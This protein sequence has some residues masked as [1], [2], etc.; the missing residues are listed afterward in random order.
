MSGLRDLKISTRKTVP[1]ALLAVRFS[2]SGG[3][4]GQNV[5]KTSTKV[6]LRLDLDAAAEVLG[7]SAVDRIRERLATRL[8]GDGCLQVVSSEHRERS[9]NLEAA[10]SRMESMIKDAL[11]PRKRRRPTKPTRASKERRLEDKK[12]RSRLKRLRSRS[13]TSE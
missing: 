12:R 1:E 2:R 11:T 6:D 10:L 8:D 7:D 9:R 5:N 3:P 4:G 13:A